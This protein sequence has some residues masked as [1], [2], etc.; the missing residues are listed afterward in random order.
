MNILTESPIRYRVALVILGF[1]FVASASLIV[2]Y[3]AF[4]PSGGLTL[5]VG[6]VAPAD[7]LSPYSLTYESEVLTRLSRQAAS[8]TIRDV[9]D[10]PN[11][12]VLRQQ[13]QLARNILDY[14]NNV[15][16]DTY[17]RPAQQMSDLDA[18]DAVRMT[19]T[20]SA[21]LLQPARRCLEGR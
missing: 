19:D 15:R 3:T 21:K 5:A 17:A 8:D 12:S 18:I 11:P 10:P 9:Y 1:V 2:A 16:H 20:V 7:I 13:I 14:I 4:V 6:Q